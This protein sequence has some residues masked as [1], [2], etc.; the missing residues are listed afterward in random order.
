M[1]AEL[2]AE[3]ERV[4]RDLDSFEFRM[5]GKNGNGIFPKKDEHSD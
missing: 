2:F 1:N 3:I 5:D 4:H